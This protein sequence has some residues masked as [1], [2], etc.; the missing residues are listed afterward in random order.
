[1][2]TRIAV[3]SLLLLAIA[4]FAQ[5]RIRYGEFIKTV[6]DTGTPEA[7]TSTNLWVTSVTLKGV[8][9]ARTANTS[10]CYVGFLATDNSQAF[11]LSSA[12]EIVIQA[13]SGATLNLAHIYIDVLSNGDGVAVFYEP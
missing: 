8:K 3:A 12:G 11:A 4:V 7:I 1:M 5:T 6:A 2:K 9:A 10:T 13:R